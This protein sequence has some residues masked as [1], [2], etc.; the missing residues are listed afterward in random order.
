MLFLDGMFINL[1]QRNKEVVIVEMVVKQV[2]KC[3]MLIID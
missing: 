1:M 3:Y 2:I